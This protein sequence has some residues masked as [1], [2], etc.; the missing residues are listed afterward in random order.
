MR[1]GFLNINRD[2]LGGLGHNL[3]YWSDSGS[4]KFDAY[5]L[6]TAGN[7]Y[8]SHGPLARYCGFS[9]RCL[10][11]YSIFV[12]SGGAVISLGFLRLAGIVGY[13]WSRS[14][15]VSTRAY[16]LDFSASEVYP[17]SGPYN[18]YSGF[19][20][21]F[22]GVGNF[23]RSGNPNMGNGFLRASGLTAYYWSHSGET[24]T[25]T[26]ILSFNDFTTTPLAKP[27]GRFYGFSLRCLQE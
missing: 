15:V 26:Y 10:Q 3:Y 17:S 27:N 20:P 13:Y 23:V 8:P 12:R 11:E 19:S 1:S 6:H 16:T 5:L 24:S 18:R 4:A 22:A 2:F 9:F 25:A 14:G 7:V 21:L